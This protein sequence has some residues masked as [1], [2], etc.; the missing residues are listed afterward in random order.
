[1]E[2]SKIEIIK[3]VPQCALGESPHWCSEEQVLYFVD[4]LKSR[5]LRFD[6]VS[7]IC[8]F[9]TV[10][11]KLFKLSV[12]RDLKAISHKSFCNRHHFWS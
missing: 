10:S 2:N 6:P 7:R 9:V 3:E 8:N 1:M 11:G 5:V 4:I 12:H